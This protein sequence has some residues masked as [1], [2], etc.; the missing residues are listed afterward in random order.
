MNFQFFTAGELKQYNNNQDA[1]LKEF[2]DMK[3]IDQ[4]GQTNKEIEILLV[5][6]LV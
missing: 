1:I 3:F 4:R 5:V 2:P 6:G